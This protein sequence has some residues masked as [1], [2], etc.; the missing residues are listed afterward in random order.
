VIHSFC[1]MKRLFIGAGI[2]CIGLC[3][4]FV[5]QRGVFQTPVISPI[6]NV[7]EKPLS[8]YTI[9][10]LSSRLYVPTQIVFDQATATTSSYT[11]FPF[12]YSSDGSL[13]TGVAHVPNDASSINKKPVIVQFR[14]YVD[15]RQYIPGTGT[16]RSAEVFAQ[17]G[18]ISLAPDFLGYGGSASPSSDVFEERFQTYTTAIYLLESVSTVPFADASRI[19]IWGHSNGGQIALTVLEILRKPIPTVLWAPVSKP[20]PYSILYYTDDADD[21]GKML[22]KVLAQ[23]EKDYDV[24]AY[25]LTNYINRIATTLQVHQ[26]SADDA[27][28]QKWSDDLVAALKMSDKNVSY[29]VY[30]GADHNMMGSWNTVVSRDILFFRNNFK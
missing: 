15:Q 23:F 21:H 4:G 20:F 11:V 30:P 3:F 27:V 5:V 8:K 1:T 29:F 14:G 17:N 24:E 19:G 13:V 2:F 10:Q 12:H 28:P 16:A 25:S 18:F 26:G 22:R 9:G 7:T 6:G